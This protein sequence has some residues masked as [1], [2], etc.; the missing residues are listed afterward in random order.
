MKKS[1]KKPTSR[2]PSWNTT[3]E[4]EIL[5]RR[6]RAASE[7]MSVIRIDNGK[8]IFSD[9]KVRRRDV[10]KPVEYT[11]EI[12]SLRDRFNYCE[13]PD[14]AKNHLGT[15]KHIEKILS[16]FKSTKM[17]SPFIEIFVDF[18]ENSRLVIT[19]P[20]KPEGEAEQFLDKYLD[21]AGNFKHPFANSLQVFLR[22][23]D[24][25]PVAIKNGIRVSIGTR[26]LASKLSRRKRNEEVKKQYADELRRHAGEA[27]FLRYPLYDYQIDGMLH[28]A[29]T[30]RAMLADEM[31]LGKTVQAVAAANVLKNIHGIRRVLVICPASLKSEWEEQI[32]KFTSLSATP[33]FG[34]RKERLEVY[35]NCESF[36]LISNYE[37]ILRDYEEINELFRPDLLILDEAQRIKNWKTKTAKRIK[38]LE[39]RFA[40]VLT[41]TPIE[42]KID[43]LYSLV[44]FIDPTVFGSLFRFNRE[45]YNFNS[46]GKT[47]GFRNLRGLH[48]KIKPVMLRRRKDEIAEQLPERVDNNYFITITQ[49]QRDRYAEYENMV[50]QLMAIAKK[51]PLRPEEHDRLQNFLACMRM[52]CDT[53]Y[54]LDQK[55]TESPKI[56]EL[57]KILT[58]IWDNDPERK[59]II[60]SEWVRMLDLVKVQLEENSVG[61]AWHVGSVP[62]HLRRQEI[63]KFKNDADC[64]VF[65]SSDSGGV[66]LN[67]Q[68]ASVVINMDLPWNPAKLEQRIAR[69]WRKHQRN[70]VNVINL[71]AEN[72][73]EHKMIATIGFKQSL[74]DG[75]LDARGDIDE[76]ERP[77]AKNAFVERL[78]ELMQ[79]KAVVAPDDEFEVLEPEEQKKTERELF[80]EEITL[81]PGDATKLCAPIPNDEGDEL[82]AVFAVSNHP[83]KAVEHITKI[84]DKTHGGLSRKDITVVDESTYK[85]LLALSEKGLITINEAIV[86]PAFKTESVT[87]RKPKLMMR[88]IKMARD[89]LAG[90]ERKLKMAHVLAAGGF[91]DEAAAPARESALACASALS[92]LP[93]S[94]LPPTPP[95][96]FNPGLL[97]TLKSELA[98]DDTSFLLIKECCETAPSKKMDYLGGATALLEEA[99][100]ILNEKALTGE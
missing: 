23:Y 66:G 9:Y 53:C 29:F 69:A 13:C 56:D 68:A 75:V 42:N 26:R 67:L 50:A 90:A 19:R 95:E 87:P 1:D 5:R 17:S 81:D 34:S 57:V 35:K 47:E 25:A 49:E 6:E 46:E 76:I 54:I 45:Y 78:A 52:L 44:D 89:V 7:S 32:A 80:D 28:L 74:A 48:E 8:R 93:M 64:K 63:N 24:E 58:E 82:K 10:E 84:A 71:V 59:V 30:E 51:R 21:P 60:F 40:F 11:V 98:I 4:D 2:Y 100:R 16:R 92:I 37:Q 20:A 86:N 3:D 88:K 91:A 33:L 18:S 83:K 96:T 73:I 15:C 14:F 12:R 85:L 27:T 70:S 22:D 72:T 62:Q 61:F 94:E 65:L 77:N 97:D 38:R 43:E 31:G 79:T 55:I 99:E 41:G 39:S 36:F